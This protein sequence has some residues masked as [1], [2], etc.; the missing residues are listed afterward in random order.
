MS[1]QGSG[2]CIRSKWLGCVAASLLL[3]M[4]QPT[5]AEPV[6]AT[7][8]RQAETPRSL[9][10]DHLSHPAY[11]SDAELKYLRE[12]YGVHGPQVPF[13][14]WVTQQVDSFPLR[15]SQTLEIVRRHR[16][17]IREIATKYQVN[18]M[19]LGAIL[20]DEVN[21]AKPGEDLMIDTGWVKTI[22]LAQISVSELYHQGKFEREALLDPEITAVGREYLKDPENNIRTL[23]RKVRRL[24]RELGVSA[25]H[26]LEI[27]NGYREA[28]ALATIAYL[29]N[30][31]QD[32]P[33][34]ILDYMED[35]DLHAVLFDPPARLLV[36]EA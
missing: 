30:G 14:Q 22:G 26:P 36:V 16:T 24:K 7:S 34:R 29:H 19:F 25:D 4:A 23:A 8:L 5:P 17:L 2:W 31:F 15:R 35:P 33:V 27:S 3:A 32:Y 1:I 9:P 18:P 12:R 10:A 13:L 11:F 28:H 21:H 20:Y 6:D